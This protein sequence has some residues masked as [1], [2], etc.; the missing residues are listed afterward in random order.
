MSI[1]MTQAQVRDMKLSIKALKERC[2]R[3]GAAIVA[4]ARIFGKDLL[5]YRRIIIKG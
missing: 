5:E 2:G 4:F 3:R 1:E